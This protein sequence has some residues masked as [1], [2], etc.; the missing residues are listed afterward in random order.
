MALQ[1]CD[2][3]L[4]VGGFLDQGLVPLPMQ[5]SNGIVANGH[6]DDGNRDQRSLDEVADNACDK[7]VGNEDNQED[8]TAKSRHELGWLEPTEKSVH[9]IN[10][11]FTEPI[12]KI[13]IWSES[14]GVAGR[15]SQP[16]RRRL[17][18]VLIFTGQTSENVIPNRTKARR[19]PGQS[20]R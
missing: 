17:T 3:Q 18:I 9:L 8:I 19:C 15:T 2:L 16:W 12:G 4:P 10:P 6:D 11:Q 14:N 1:V 13:C 7:A 5:G 20:L